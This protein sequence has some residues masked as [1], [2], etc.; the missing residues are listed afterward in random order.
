MGARA[1]AAG[2]S[3]RLRGPKAVQVEHGTGPGSSG[4]LVFCGP[5]PP[6]PTGI[7]TYDR[8]VLDGLER[9]GFNDRASSAIIDQGRMS[10]PLIR[11]AAESA[12]RTF[13]NPQCTPLKLPSDKYEVWKDLVVNF[14]PRDLL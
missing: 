12:R 11:A 6:A 9:I 7:A 14:D 10:D 4:E 2:V 8:A 3:R 5:L 13:F 1:K